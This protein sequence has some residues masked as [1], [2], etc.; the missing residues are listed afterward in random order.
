L[1]TEDIKSLNSIN[2]Q[3]NELIKNDLNNGEIPGLVVYSSG[4]TGTHKI[5]LLK[6]KSIFYYVRPDHTIYIN[7]QS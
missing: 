6:Q 5:I 2:K 1:S 7:R 3:E 4:S